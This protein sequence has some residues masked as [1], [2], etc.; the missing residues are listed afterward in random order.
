MKKR[1]VM[2]VMAIVSMLC[3]T[4]SVAAQE[5]A[6]KGSISADVVSSYV[7][8][9]ATASAAPNIQPTAS[10]N[11]KNFTMGVW[12]SFD[13]QGEYKEVDF[14]LTYSLKDLSLTLTDYN[15]GFQEKYF[16]YKKARTEHILEA[17]LS[18]GGSEAFPLK[19]T[20]ATMFYG[21][22]KKPA[23]P[24]KNAYSTY[25]EFSYAIG[26]VTPFVGATFDEGMYGTGAGV[27]NVGVT[28]TKEVKISS[29]YSLPL[30]CTFAVNPRKEDVFLVF[31]LRL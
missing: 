12:G 6:L 31:G 30:F 5:G 2:G 11:W 13:L 4:V 22:D 25:A 28:A 1:G 24:S 7:W 29:D 14:F 9:G 26:S 18:Y 15:W 27:V 20:V 17:A 8:R 19:M 10:L 21:Q 16:M 23:D 3:A